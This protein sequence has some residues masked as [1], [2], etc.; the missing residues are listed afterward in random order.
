[1][2]RQCVTKC[3]IITVTIASHPIQQNIPPLTTIL[4]DETNIV[5]DGLQDLQCINHMD[6][7][8]DYYP[9]GLQDI[10][11]IPIHSCIDSANKEGVHLLLLLCHCGNVTPQNTSKC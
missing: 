1:M 3:M 5:F 2:M 7:A 11:P 10:F 8:P 6:M 9:D 4:K